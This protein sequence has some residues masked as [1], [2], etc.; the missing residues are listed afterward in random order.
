MGFLKQVELFKVYY[1]VVYKQEEA[2]EKGRVKLIPETKTIEVYNRNFDYMQDTLDFFLS[3]LA[4][5]YLCKR[6]RLLNK[7]IPEAQYKDSHIMPRT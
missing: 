3:G 1:T 5:E 7:S 6:L 2:C 4:M